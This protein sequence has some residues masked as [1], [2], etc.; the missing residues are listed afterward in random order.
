MIIGRDLM[1]ELKMDVIYSDNIVTWDVLTLPMQQDK[2]N[3]SWIDME[4]LFKDTT[5]S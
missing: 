4:A 3:V 5:E 1:R 2:Q